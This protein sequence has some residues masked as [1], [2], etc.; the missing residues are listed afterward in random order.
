[1]VIEH[2]KQG[3][4]RPISERFKGKGRM[5]PEG[6]GYHAS[7]VDS[8]GARC[9]QIMEAGHPQLLDAWIACW[10]DLVDFEIIPV[11]TSADFWARPQSEGSQ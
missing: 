11:M 8:T 10:D 4:P 5:S 3:N 1:M 9:F 7:W 2:F 6:V